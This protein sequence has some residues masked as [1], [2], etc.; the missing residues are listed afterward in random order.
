MFVLQTLMTDWLTSK[1]IFFVLF[2]QGH[3]HLEMP[4]CSSVFSAASSKHFSIPFREGG[5]LATCC[6][7]VKFRAFVLW[8]WKQIHTGIY[9][10]LIR[11]PT[12]MAQNTVFSQGFGQSRLVILLFP[13][14]ALK[15]PGIMRLMWL[16]SVPTVPMPYPRYVQSCDKKKDTADFGYN[17]IECFII[18]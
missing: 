17:S 15:I 3:E 2:F 12:Q 1:N 7:P 4:I 16:A 13:L 14:F 18:L 10:E 11:S 6:M 8:G 5:S 9:L